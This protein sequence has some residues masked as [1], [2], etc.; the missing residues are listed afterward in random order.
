ML[1]KIIK[2]IKANKI[3]FM[4]SDTIYGLFGCALSSR[5]V[6]EIYSLKSRDP[7]KPLIIMLSS[8]DDLL[9][10][11]VNLNQKEREI[12]ERIW[13]EKVS[14]VLP[15]PSEKFFYLHRGKNTL[16]F[17]L[18]KN[19]ELLSILENTGPLVSTSANLEGK[20][21]AK[22]VAEAKKYFGNKIN[23]Y[24][25]KGA[26]NSPPSTLIKINNGEIEIL[27]KGE[28]IINQTILS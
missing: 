26:I 4:P 27:R 14:V 17:R 9:L 18:P 21:Y 5:T 23:L 22:T 2:Q 8:I 15:V 12:L 3:V 19:E 10:F 16:A 28:F 25:N 11:E 6:E 20:S 7:R 13:P 1:T 24:I